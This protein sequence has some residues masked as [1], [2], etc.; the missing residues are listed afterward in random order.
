MF[1]ISILQFSKAVDRT[2]PTTVLEVEGP[3]YLKDGIIWISSNS[4]I[5]LNSTDDESGARFLIYEVWYDSNKDGII[6]SKIEEKQIED[7]KA[8]DLNPN[9]G[10]ISAKIILNEECFHEIKYYAYDYMLNKEN[11][12]LELYE[13]WNY[14]FQTGVNHEINNMIFGSS[15]AIGNITG[16]REYELSLIH[17]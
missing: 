11:Y 6:D 12:G 7:N 16:G 5:W 14:P 1:I 3:S 17:I 4:T 15:P 10:E 2:P 8:G 13:E 9:A